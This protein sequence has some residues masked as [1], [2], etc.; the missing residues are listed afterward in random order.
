VIAEQLL[1]VT[2]GVDHPLVEKQH[3]APHR[4]GQK[5]V[6]GHAQHADVIAAQLVDDVDDLAGHERVECRGG[7]VEEQHCR[8]HGQRAGNGHPLLLPAGELGG[9][10]VVMLHHIHAAQFMFGAFNRLPQRHTAQFAQAEGDVV[11]HAQVAVEGKVLKHKADALAQGAH[12]GIGAGDI[13]VAENDLPGGGCDQPVEAA[14][15]GG[16]AAP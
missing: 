8:V 6:V 2:F 1:G 3:P 15:Q 11:E 10:F 12:I 5:E 7:F 14:Q 4:A 16:F 9:V 13:L